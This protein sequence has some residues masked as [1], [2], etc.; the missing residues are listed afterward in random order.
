MHGLGVIP[1]RKRERRGRRISFRCLVRRN[2]TR[3]QRMSLH[4]R[5][6]RRRCATWVRIDSA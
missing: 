6:L 1:S 2:A 3:F 4:L 5:H